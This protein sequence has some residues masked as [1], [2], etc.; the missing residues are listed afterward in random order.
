VLKQAL[1]AY[2]GLV[3]MSPKTTPIA[4]KL[5]AKIPPLL[6]ATEFPNAKL[7]RYLDFEYSGL[8]INIVLLLLL[9]TKFK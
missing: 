2:K 9:S 6:W 5:R 8:P 3:P 7:G 4:A 1:N